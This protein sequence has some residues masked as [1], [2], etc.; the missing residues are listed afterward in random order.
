MNPS[1]TYNGHLKTH[2]ASLWVLTYTLTEKQK[3]HFAKCNYTNTPLWWDNEE[4]D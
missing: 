4:D 3:A 1:L 2:K